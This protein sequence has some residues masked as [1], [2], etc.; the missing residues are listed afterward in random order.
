MIQMLRRNSYVRI[1][2]DITDIKLIFKIGK[3]IFKWHKYISLGDFIHQESL[4][5]QTKALL[6]KLFKTPEREGEAS[7]GNEKNNLKGI[8]QMAWHQYFCNCISVG[9]RKMRLIYMAALIA[10]TRLKKSFRILFP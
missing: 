6:Y 9:K 10:Q 3:R 1:H 2:I 8:K 4:L 7:Y 5:V